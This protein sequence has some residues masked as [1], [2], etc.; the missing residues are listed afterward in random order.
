MSKM[1]NGGTPAGNGVK[2]NGKAKFVEQAKAK[3]SAH[4]KLRAEFLAKYGK[5]IA[6]AW[7]ALGEKANSMAVAAKV[8]P[9]QPTRLVDYV[10][11]KLGLRESK[12]LGLQAWLKDDLVGAVATSQP[13][14]KK[15]GTK[16]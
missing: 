14:A 5:A 1:K 3:Q 13:K 9:D 7:S 8:L 4:R 12:D 11:L 16:A 10:T 6:S 2:K 15:N